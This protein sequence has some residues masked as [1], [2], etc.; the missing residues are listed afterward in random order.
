MRE[1]PNIDDL[2]YVAIGRFENGNAVR[3]F[4]T[5][6]EGDEITVSGSYSSVKCKRLEAVV[7]P[8]EDYTPEELRLLDWFKQFGPSS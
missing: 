6:F 5:H 8:P 2:V 1:N 4:V 3:G 7:I